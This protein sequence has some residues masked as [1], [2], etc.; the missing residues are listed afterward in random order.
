MKR[1]ADLDPAQLSEA[2]RQVYDAIAAGPRQGVPGPLAVW[3]RRPELAAHAQALGRY[4]RY[5]SSLP[6][7]LSELAILTLARIW[8]SEYEWYAHKPAALAAGLD[9]AVVEALRTHAAPPFSRHDEAL[10]HH[11]LVTLHRDRRIADDLYADAVAALGEAGVVDLIG[12][13]GYYT[14]ISMTINVFQVE[15]PAGT[16]MELS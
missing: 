12:I 7:R 8:G 13:A 5:D 3:L 1:I 2:Q 11:L 16:P 10:V 6:P 15:P 9:A 14:L 4:C